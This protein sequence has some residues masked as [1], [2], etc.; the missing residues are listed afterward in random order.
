MI[1]ALRYNRI[2]KPEELRR[3]RAQLGLTQARFAE[4]LG[5][6]RVTVARWET[7]IIGMSAT[8][9]RLIALLDVPG[10]TEVT[11]KKPNQ[12]QPKRSKR[13]RRGGR[14]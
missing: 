2:V 12:A 9:K 6:N 8:T 1:V 7:G 10:A 3:I 13:T 11:T 5:V 14:N 4:L